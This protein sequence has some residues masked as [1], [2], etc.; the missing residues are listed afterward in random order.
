MRQERLGE[1][2]PTSRLLSTMRGRVSESQV[3][4]RSNQQSDAISVVISHYSGLTNMRICGKLLIM[5]A[6][7]VMLISCGRSTHP[8][9]DQPENATA[10]PDE[11]GLGDPI[12]L[13]AR[14]EYSG[15]HTIKD[16][17]Q[18]GT[19]LSMNIL[20][21][22]LRSGKGPNAV[23][24]VDNTT[25]AQIQGFVH[26]SGRADMTSTDGAIEE[27]YDKAGAWTAL[28]TP[29]SGFS[30]ITM[31]EPSDI[32]DGLQMTVEVHVPVVGDVWIQSG[33]QKYPD[34][35]FARPLECTERDDHLEDQGPACFVKFSIDPTPSGPKSDAGKIVYDKIVEALK[36]PNG[37][38]LMG[39]LG[40]I[41]GA[42][43]TYDG[44]GNFA[45]HVTKSYLVDKDGSKF[46]INVDITVWSS[47]RGSNAA[48]KNVT[49]VRAS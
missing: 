45:T 10:A 41:Y 17:G 29:K 34:V 1:K 39:M 19:T 22:A 36:Q 4:V 47:K 2:L 30:S 20:Q 18:S 38:A 7:A 23:Y 14:I 48:P 42:Q 12:M 35:T 16:V 6:T 28:G 31:P 49:P 15:R 5:A 9:A 21:S 3:D 32:G 11:S 25:P 8:V 27:H 46:E 26:G 40:Q 33:G 37:E 44:D 24:S 13:H 43:S